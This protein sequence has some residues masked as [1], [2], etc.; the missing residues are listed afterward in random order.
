MVSSTYRAALSS[1][2]GEDFSGVDMLYRNPTP[3]R[4]AIGLLQTFIYPWASTPLGCVVFGL[5]AI[6]MVAL[7]W[8]SRRAAILVTTLALPYTVF[9]L[10]FQE[11]VTTRYALPLIPL[12]AFLAVG[13]IRVLARTSLRQAS[14]AVAAIV[15]WSLALTLPARA[16][17]RARGVPHSPR[18]RSC[19][20]SFRVNRM[21]PSECIRAFCGRCRRRI[22]DPRRS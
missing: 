6:G 10:L 12:I 21:P 19:T 15:V 17:T 13:G 7:L 5:A 11:T 3:R 2:G 1:Q 18:W 9:H 14:A 16:Y 8:R 4:L 20:A 22:S